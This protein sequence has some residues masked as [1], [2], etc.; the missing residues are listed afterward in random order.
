MRH[1]R[2][3]PGVGRD[4]KRPAR[5][6]QRDGAGMTLFRADDVREGSQHAEIG[7]HALVD[8]LGAVLVLDAA[9]E[10]GAKLGRDGG[11]GCNRRG[12]CR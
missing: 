12:C 9:L 8:G 1:R 6:H 4:R 7:D 3:R 2:D 10:R 11:R 5:E